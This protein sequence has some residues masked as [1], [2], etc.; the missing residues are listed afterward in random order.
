MAHSLGLQGYRVLC[1]D[2]DP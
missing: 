2:L 1:I